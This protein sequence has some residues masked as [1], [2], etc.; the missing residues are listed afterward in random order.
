MASLSLSHGRSV[1]VTWPNTRLGCLLFQ[2]LSNKMGGPRG[3]QQ[4]R[5]LDQL[6][7]VSP[8]RFDVDADVC[9]VAVSDRNAAT[10][11][12]LVSERGSCFKRDNGHLQLS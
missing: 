9:R 5:A 7:C 1:L 3:T 4:V 10:L 2:K 12:T 6:C 8:D 11:R